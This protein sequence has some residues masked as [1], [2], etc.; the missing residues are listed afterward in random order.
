MACVQAMA[1]YALLHYAYLI[2]Y[3]QILGISK[4]W[5]E[6]W[7][8]GQVIRIDDALLR[9]HEVSYALLQVQ[10]QIYSSIEASRTT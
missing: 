9:L 4:C 10:V 1:W 7:H 2:T 5:Q 8:S 6:A 3:D